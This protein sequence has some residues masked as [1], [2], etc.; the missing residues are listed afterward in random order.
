MTISVRLRW[1][2]QLLIVS[3]CLGLVLPASAI[4]IRHDTGYSRFLARE[5]DYPAVFPLQ[6]EQGQKTCVATLI[7]RRWA[8]T[9]AHCTAQTPIAE[10]IAARGR[11]SVTIA[12]ESFAVD[13]LVLHPDWPAPA[14]RGF[15][16]HHI[17]LALLRLQT[18]VTHIDA[19][20]LYEA[21]DE[22]GQ[23]M[24]FLGWGYSGIGRTGTAVNDGR[25]R[26][27]RNEVSRAD[28]KL[29]FHFNDPDGPRSTAVDFEGI[30][31]LGDSG[32][33]ALLNVDGMQWLAGVAVGELDTDMA[34]TVWPVTGRYGATVVYERVSSHA[35][36]INQVIAAGSVVSP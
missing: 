12:G 27:A 2:L 16:P 25:F 36:W 21:G 33:P 7:S 17:D 1:W 13:Q 14:G 19:L 9:A 35:D 34:G 6:V 26:F 3:I 29:Y 11:Y 31:G 30:P 28:Q 15:D 32:G 20:P 23:V 5:S 22:L 18:E 10:Q 8:I 24:T 4:I